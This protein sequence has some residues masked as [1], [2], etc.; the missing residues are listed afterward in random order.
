MLA[1]EDHPDA[2][3][4]EGQELVAGLNYLTTRDGVELAVTVRLPA[5]KTLD[6]GP[7]PTVIEYSGYPVAPPG[8]LLASILDPDSVDPNVPLPSTSTAVGSVIAPLLGFA[9]VSVQMRG[10][11]CSGGAFGLF[12]I[13]TTLDGYDA[14]ETVAAQPWVKNGK[15]GMVGISFSGISQLFVAGSQPPSLA[16]IAPLSV[17]DDLYSTG[18][19]GGIYNDGFAATWIAERIEEAKPASEGG[20]PWAATLIEQGDERC[21]ANQALHS[22]AQQMDDVLQGETYRIPAPF[23]ERSPSVWAERI[24]VPTFLVGAFQD[25]QTGGQWPNLVPALAGN[26]DTWVTLLNGTHVD[27]LG[28]LSIGRWAEFLSLYVADELPTEATSVVALSGAIYDELAGVEAAPVPPIRFLDASSVEDAKAEFEQ[29]PR[30]RVLFDN[31]GGGPVGPGALEPLWEASFDA[32]PPQEVEATTWYLGDDGALETEAADDESEATYGPDPEARPRTSLP[33]GE[34]PWAALPKYDWAPVSDGAGLGFVTA[35]LEEDTALIGTGSL[36]LMLGSTAEDTDIQVTLSEVRPDGEE[37]YVQTGFLRASRRALDERSTDLLVAPTFQEGD[38]EPLPQDALT[39][40]R[41]P[42]PPMAHMFRAGSRI[43]I[44]ITA[45]GGD[46]P[47]WTLDTFDTE[48]VTNTVGLGGDEASAL[49]LPVVPGLE[50]E[51]PLPPCPSNRGQPCRPY[52]PA[53]NGG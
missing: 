25:E 33:A 7:F 3:L 11:G 53:A 15:V 30:I 12:D 29:D 45:P 46:R 51:T 42:I 41:V 36:N 50:A 27:S 31:G 2:A 43:R 5:G 24:E 9:T 1:P 44:S 6:D 52:E 4:Y 37:M 23:D 20:Q 26:E 47:A 28:P 19:P 39:E 10:T 16:A 18:Y 17:T 13:L 22:Q 38:D 8:D 49:V 34:D 40:V 48:D 35:E 14:V 21:E 32:W